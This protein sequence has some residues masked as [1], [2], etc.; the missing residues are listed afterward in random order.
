MSAPVLSIASGLEIALEAFAQSGFRAGVWASSGRGKSHTV[1]V[2]AEELLGCGLPVVA[3]DPEGEL[4][5]L[6]EGYRTLVVGGPHADLPA[7]SSRA[8][9]REV[10]STAL[11][12]RLAC[13]FDLSEAVTNAT[14]QEMARPVLE[15]L[16]AL[17]T[18]E[19][20]TVG[21][22]LEEVQVFAPQSTPSSTSEIMARIAKQG[23]KR[24]ILLVV[25]SQR[26]QA[27]S[28][29]FMSQ[30][31]FPIVGGFEERVDFEAV[32][33]HAGRKTFEDLNR[34]DVGFFWFPRISRLEKIRG[35]K[36]THGGDTPELG[37]EIVLK[38]EVTDQELAAAVAGL[39][40]A[41]RKAEEQERVERGEIAQLKRRVEELEALLGAKDEEI[42][43][44]EIALKVSAAQNAAHQRASAETRKVEAVQVH[45][46]K[47]EVSGPQARP[48]PVRSPEA[49]PILPV[50]VLTALPAVPGGPLEWVEHPAIRDL[51]N[52]AMA[53]ARRRLK[54]DGAGYCSFALAA[55][56]RTKHL[57]AQEMAMAMGIPSDRS[58][59]R[60]KTA[61]DELTTFGLLR[62]NA[63]K[64]YSLD[65]DK[66]QQAVALAE[67]RAARHRR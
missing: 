2:I 12:Q 30:L 56:A 42:A 24:G 44:F 4:W 52:R 35:R 28:K 15:E 32:K 58:I 38:Q 41:M 25:A 53:A 39:A 14:Q 1:G 59:R 7:T 60:V 23:R 33:H 57:K 20:R 55:L 29:E 9:I 21:L 67:A 47:V 11:A 34:L 13:V 26:T 48:R 17:Q 22:I 5:T 18:R 19:R 36:V 10:L 46:E 62:A 16:F 3:I 43:Q 64:S 37:G 54:G 66:I 45:A 65:S 51:L 31:N 61:C 6:R 49:Q 50:N 40:E 8:C 27:V 63:D